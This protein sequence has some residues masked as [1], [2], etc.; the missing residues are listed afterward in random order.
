MSAREVAERFV[1]EIGA[2]TRF[3]VLNFANPDMVGHTGVIPAVVSA[4]ETVDECLG[5]DGRRRG[6]AGRGLPRHG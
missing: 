2:A 3:A 5:R 4:V 6:G 1:A